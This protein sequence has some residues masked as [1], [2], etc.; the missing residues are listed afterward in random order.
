M[1]GRIR[2]IETR[3]QGYRFRS[4]LEARWAVF[5]DALGVAY[6]YEHEGYITRE[7][8]YLPD[9]YFPDL[10]LFGEVKPTA[11]TT[12]EI[13][14]CIDLSRTARMPVIL[15]DDGPPQVRWYMAIMPPR[16]EDGKHDI[17][18]LDWGASARAGYPL[19]TLGTRGWPEFSPG[20][21]D[22]FKS[23]TESARG[24]RFEHGETP[25]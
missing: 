12:P 5:F 18:F 7:G 4:R 8:G 11:F 9:F 22:A 2:A 1:N 21:S 10:R 6:L 17:E 19:Y 13:M 20:P 3:Y 14:K 25:Q 16:E 24:A 23:A 15:L